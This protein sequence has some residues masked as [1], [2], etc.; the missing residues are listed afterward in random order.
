VPQTFTLKR[1]TDDKVK[2]TYRY[3]KS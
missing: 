2:P 1:N 3:R